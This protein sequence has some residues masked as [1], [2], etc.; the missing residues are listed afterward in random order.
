MRVKYY[1]ENYGNRIYFTLRKTKRKTIGI[2]VDE[3]GEVKVHV[4][5]C[6]SEKQV[7][8]V[9]QKKTD[10]IVK[11]VNEVTEKNSNLEYR[12]FVSGEKFLYLGKEYTLEIVEKDLSKSEV[13]IQED[14]M[15]VYIPKG[16][17]AE[18]RKQVIEVALIKWY[19]Q[20]FAEIAKERIDKYS[21]Q[22]KV[23]PLK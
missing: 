5:F 18:S 23:A 12:Q 11:K 2:I 19:R 1:I 4:P 8:E 10:W 14:T 13:L 9:V 22:L 3:N 17:Y 6:V 16:L 15:A 7:C 21:L 20:C